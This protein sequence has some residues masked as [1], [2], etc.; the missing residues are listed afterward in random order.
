MVRR[1]NARYKF[2]RSTAR[3]G[4]LLKMKAWEDD[5]AAVVGV[6]PLWK[7]ENELQQD[8]L[9]H[10]KRSSAAGGLVEL[11]MLGSLDLVMEDGTEFN[12]GTGFTM[13]ERRELWK[14]R[15]RLLTRMVTF[16]HQPPPGGRPAGTPPR[17]PVFKG[18]RHPDD[19]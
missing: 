18:F 16:K 8:E 14:I 17:I 11:D 15:G 6:Q 2:G 12:V 4:I 5:E 10:A 19:L 7:N 1:P 3:E 13:E 9:G